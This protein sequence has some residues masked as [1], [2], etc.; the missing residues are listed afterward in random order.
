ML[1]VSFYAKKVNT[2]YVLSLIGHCKLH[3]TE[4][5]P[6]GSASCIPGGAVWLHIGGGAD[7]CGTAWSVSTVRDLSG[8]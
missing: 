5:D 1:V 6:F 4:V 2:W 7:R 8:I 3:P